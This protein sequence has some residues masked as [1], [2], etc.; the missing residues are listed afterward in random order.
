MI[1]SKKSY[2]YYLICDEKANGGSHRPFYIANEIKKY[3]KILRKSEYILYKLKCENRYRNFFLRFYHVLLKYELHKLGLK[4]GFGIPENTLGPG[5]K[6]DH[7]GFIAINSNVKI[8]KNCHI[9]GDITIGIKNNEGI[10]AP[11]IGDNV[12]IGAGARI[13]GPIKIASN[14]VIGANAVVTRS[15]LEEGTVI[16]GIPATRIR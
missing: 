12:T 8:G 3:L 6:I 7:W 10:G 4:L 11:E 2:Y 13:I 15:F 9:F 14:C 5:V 16:G 1:D